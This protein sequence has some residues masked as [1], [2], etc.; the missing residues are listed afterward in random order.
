MSLG[1]NR[2]AGNF[3]PLCGVAEAAV[4]LGVTTGRVRQLITRGDLH[5]VQVLKATPVFLEADVRALAETRSTA[6]GRPV[7]EV[8]P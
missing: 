4:I 2:T 8:K 7:K 1:A 3:P 5:P 6:P